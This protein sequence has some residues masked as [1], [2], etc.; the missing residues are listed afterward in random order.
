MR[1]IKKSLLKNKYKGKIVFSFYCL[2]LSISFSFI[3]CASTF[4]SSSSTNYAL[5]NDNCRNPITFTSIQKRFDDLK[6]LKGIARVEIKFKDRSK[7]MTGRAVIVIKRP[8]TFRLDFLGPFNQT[9]AVMTYNGINLSLLSFQEKRIYK[10]YPFPTDIKRLPSYL[11]GAPA[12]F[13][14]SISKSCLLENEVTEGG[15]SG[16]KLLINSAGNIVQ[17]ISSVDN[18]QHLQTIQALMDSYK[19]VN[20]LKFPFIISINNEAANISIKYDHLELNQQI[21][22]D[23]FILPQIP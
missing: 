23:S 8:D 16:E 19:E 3:G 6:T 17:I 15:F 21:S 12:D 20:G 4:F 22:D 18:N 1:I 9:I 2:L 5:K 13:P 10:D 11:M 14:S 7:D